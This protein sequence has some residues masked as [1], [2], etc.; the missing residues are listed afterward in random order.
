[1]NAGYTE[2]FEHLGKEDAYSY[3]FSGASGQ[4]DH[5]L[6]NAMML[7]S[8]VDAT[9]WHINADEPIVLDYNVEFKSE[10]QQDSYYSADPYRA[11]DHD[12]VVIAVN[13]ESSATTDTANSEANA[14]NT[15]PVTKDNDNGGSVP[16]SVLMF[17]SLVLVQRHR[18]H[19]LS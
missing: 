14:T 9:E 2:L 11:S 19:T 3:V 5:A 16:A 12:P 18:R 13:L 10:S 17:L 15:V 4:L 8:V 6:A 7:T 1:M